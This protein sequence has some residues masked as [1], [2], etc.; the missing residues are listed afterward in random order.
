MAISG[1]T[2]SD[3]AD[4]GDAS[5]KIVDYSVTDQVGAGHVWAHYYN[6]PSIA[7]AIR[8]YVYFDECQ[9]APELSP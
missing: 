8:H 6:Q 4:M 1:V 3:R 2:R 5:Q 9:I 7:E